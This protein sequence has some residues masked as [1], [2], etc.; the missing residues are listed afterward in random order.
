[1]NIFVK[2]APGL[3]ILTSDLWKRKKTAVNEV[4]LSPLFYCILVQL[5]QINCLYVSKNRQKF[6]KREVNTR[7]QTYCKCLVSPGKWHSTIDLCTKYVAL[8]GWW[9]TAS[10]RELNAHMLALVFHSI[11]DFLLFLRPFTRQWNFY[12]HDLALLKREEKLWKF[13]TRHDHCAVTSKRVSLVA[14][15]Q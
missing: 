3:L 14:N 8:E 9:A 12:S 2:S 11:A 5:Y 13:P 10:W 6:H 7:Q 4:S 15:R 1:M